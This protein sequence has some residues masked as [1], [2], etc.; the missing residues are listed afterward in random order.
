MT[1]TRR[2]IVAACTSILVV[3]A[4]LVCTT[5]TS[6]TVVSSRSI[7]EHL[8]GQRNSGV[9]RRRWPGEIGPAQPT[10]RLHDRTGWQHPGGR[11]LQQQDPANPAERRYY[12]GGRERQRNLQPGDN[13]QATSASLS[14]PHDVTADGNGVV[15]I[16]DSAH[17]R[18]RRVSLNGVITTVA[19]TGVAGSSGDGGAAT[20]R[21]SENPKSVVL[22]GTGLYT[23]GVDNRVRRIDLAA[24]IIT[25]VAG[26][27]VAGYSGDSNPATSAR[28]NGPQRIHLD[29]QGNI[30]I[31]DTL[32]QVIRR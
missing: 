17:H 13:R 30:Y 18:I 24:G 3:V 29:S 22:H 12:D 19:G 15:Y 20:A 14:W 2:S 27:G 8:G 16:A 25:T 31:A 32:N 1:L 5:S 6:F 26:T 21:D 10:P 23:A 11:H 9:R 7:V 28:L 4:T